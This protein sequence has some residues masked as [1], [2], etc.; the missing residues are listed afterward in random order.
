MKIRHIQIKNFRNIKY[1]DI[2]I[3]NNLNIF[4]GN[5]A[6]GKTN[7]LE[8]LYVLSTGNSFRNAADKDLVSYNAPG[9]TVKIQYSVSERPVEAMLKYESNG[10]KA[11]TINNKRM[12]ANGQERLKTVLFTPD[13]LFLLKGSPA[14]RRTFLD[15]LLKQLSL[16]YAYNLDN[17]VKVLKKRN[18]LLKNEQTKSR[19]F[20]IINDLFIESAVKVIMARINL[21][22]ILEETAGPIYAQTSNG[23]NELKIKYALSFAVNNDK[24]NLSVLESALKHHLEL[25]KEKERYRRQSLAGPHLDDINFYQDGK[26]ARVYASQGQQRNIIISVKLAE[27]YILK[28]IT[29]YYPV[30]LLDEVLAELDESRRTVLLS[31]L[32]KAD[33]QTYLTSVHFDEHVSNKSVFTVNEGCFVRKEQ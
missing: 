10:P 28:K 30:F 25:I 13:D 20:A 26:A 19:S 12:L 23:L 7:F 21:I 24:I 31:H 22:N 18:N 29:G 2:P 5:N 33:F 3:N 17:Y 4:I 32:E 9:Y 1:L 6:Q 14:K 27:I 16:E 8:A 15:L 11:F